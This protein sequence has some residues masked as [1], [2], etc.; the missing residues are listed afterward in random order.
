MTDPKTHWINHFAIMLLQAHLN[1][2]LPLPFSL[3]LPIWKCQ[4]WK[5]L[6]PLHLTKWDSK[7]KWKLGHK[8]NIKQRSD[9]RGLIYWIAA[10]WIAWKSLSHTIISANSI[11]LH[12]CD[13]ELC[14]DLWKFK[15]RSK[16]IDLCSADQSLFC[17]EG[18][19]F[20]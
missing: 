12:Q 17:R 13:Y 10:V 9:L 18:H 1:A 20:I 14:N 5:V 4:L 2:H 11:Q 15:F 16:R 8:F 3:H 19:N 6:R 7:E